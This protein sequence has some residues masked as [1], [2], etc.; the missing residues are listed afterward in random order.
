MLLSF[1]RPGIFHDESFNRLL[2]KSFG[3]IWDL[4]E[5]TFQPWLD[6][7]HTN[8]ER[9]PPFEALLEKTVRLGITLFSHPCT[10]MFNWDLKRSTSRDCE[11]AIAPRL[12]K[13]NDEEA[14][15]LN[16][17]QL[18]LNI[19][20]R[21]TLEI[22]DIESQNHARPNTQ[23]FHNQVTYPEPAQNSGQFAPDVNGEPHYPQNRAISQPDPM[24]AHATREPLYQPPGQG[25][26]ETPDIY[27][28]ESDPQRRCELEGI[29]ADSRH[30]NPHPT[31]PQPT[32]M[33]PPQDRNSA[34]DESLHRGDGHARYD[35]P[36]QPYA[37]G[38]QLSRPDDSLS[39]TDL[40]GSYSPQA[41]QISQG[42]DQREVRRKAYYPPTLSANRFPTG[43][44][45]SQPV[46]RKSSRE[47]RSASADRDRSN[48]DNLAPPSRRRSIST[49]R[50]LLEQFKDTVVTAFKEP[51]HS[52]NNPP[53]MLNNRPEKQ[54]YSGIPPGVLPDPVERLSGQDS[55]AG[56][57]KYKQSNEPSGHKVIDL[58]PSYG[59]SGAGAPSYEGS[60]AGAPPDKNEQR[61]R[62]GSRQGFG[63]RSLRDDRSDRK[64][65]SWKAKFGL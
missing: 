62:P 24:S 46:R 50:N 65:R 52:G 20:T 6:P 38:N 44:T 21:R 45:E 27:E 33:L 63:D 9:N 14:R 26:P 40:V 43:S 23:A 54:K 55:K 8:A 53:G 35:P 29:N 57:G 49:D 25:P 5:I 64:K 11:I 4:F 60:G 13:I 36:S 10:F 37:Y 42:T 12:L 18:M 58:T 16:P 59:G 32:G 41:N 61:H 17:S 31:S 30:S 47:R 2:D 56:H 22:E 34:V 15:E 7:E 28:L 51:K 48:N 1:L 19:T 39:Y 3:K